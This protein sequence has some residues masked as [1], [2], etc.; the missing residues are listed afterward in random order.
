METAARFEEWIE[1]NQVGGTERIFPYSD[2]T[3]RNNVK[4]A[5]TAAGL[6]INDGPDAETYKVNRGTTFVNCHWLRHNRNTRIKKTPEPVADQQY[7]GHENTDM[8]DHYT[9]FDPDEVQGIVG[10]TR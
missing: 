7:M 1:S 9:E 10:F 6:W 2:T 5:F 3:Y 4:Y 8:T